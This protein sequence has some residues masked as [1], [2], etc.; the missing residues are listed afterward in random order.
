M[1]KALPIVFDVLYWLFFVVVYTAAGAAG[2][3]VASALWGSSLGAHA[4]AI[5]LGWIVFLHAFVV[6][7][8][9]LR[10]LV[11]PALEEG[12]SPIGANKGYVAWGFHSVF[13]GLYLAAPFREQ[14]HFLFTLRYLHYRL[15]GMKLHLSNV[16]GTGAELRQVELIE[17][18]EKT[19]I[20]IRAAMSC[21]L[22]A[23]GKSHRQARIRVGRESLIGALAQIGP[24]VTIGDRCVIGASSTISPDVRIGNDV[25]MGPGC[26]VRSGLTVGDGARLAAGSIVV[27]DVP[28]GASLAGNPAVPL[29]KEASR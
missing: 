1:N 14:I 13:Q 5:A 6:V 19:V 21:H 29:V 10:L 4:F 9:L 2:L 22:N 28:A 17:I 7:L 16:I 23:D 11:Q 12:V 27:S 24:G 8:G 26:I 15:S 20:G 18:G 25:K 3:G